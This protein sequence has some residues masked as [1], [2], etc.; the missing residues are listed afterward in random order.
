MEGIAMAAKLRRKPAG[1]Y[2]RMDYQACWYPRNP[3]HLLYANL[4]FTK[5]GVPQGFRR[6]LPWLDLVGPDWTEER[7]LRYL[8][9]HQGEYRR[10]LKWIAE[11]TTTLFEVHEGE[12]EDSSDFGFLKRWEQQDEVRLLQEHGLDHSGVDVGPLNEV[13]TYF[14]GLVLRQR[15]PRDPLD[16]LCWYLLSS[17]M[18][19]GTIQVRCCKY[20]K[21]GKFFRGQTARKV[22]CSNACRAGDFMSKKSPGWKRKR[23][24][25]WRDIRKRL[26]Q[27]RQHSSST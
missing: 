22:Y 16:P 27:R 6:L 18:W 14:S 1:N 10:C 21:C 5:P 9:E 23:I 19:E 11:G 24:R 12:T 26:A 4:D 13:G 2:L 17:L 3:P 25:E 15:K 20:S 8:K 7:T